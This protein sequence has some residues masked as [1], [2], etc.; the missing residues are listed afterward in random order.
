M[1]KPS[2]MNIYIYCVSYTLSYQPHQTNNRRTRRSRVLQP[3]WQA[4]LRGMLSSIIAAAEV[5]V[6][7]GPRINTCWRI[8]QSQKV[9]RGGAVRRPRGNWGTLKEITT[10]WSLQY[11]SWGL[12]RILPRRKQLAARKKSKPMNQAFDNNVGLPVERMLLLVIC[13]HF[14]SLC[15]QWLWLDRD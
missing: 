15:N 4:L 1:T 10:T 11:G 8:F 7:T 3:K 12:M 14:W 5:F 6:Y 2:C 13:C 9:D